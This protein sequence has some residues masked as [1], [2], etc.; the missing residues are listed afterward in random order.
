[1]VKSK[2]SGNRHYDG[3]RLTESAM[4]CPN[5][6]VQVSCRLRLFFQVQRHTSPR[7]GF[8][9]TYSEILTLYY[10]LLLSTCRLCLHGN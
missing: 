5:I 10:V 7:Y 4:G 3:N 2:R 9:D 1:M 8:M 6:C